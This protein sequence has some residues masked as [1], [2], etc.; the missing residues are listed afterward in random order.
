MLAFAGTL[1]LSQITAPAHAVESRAPITVHCYDKKRDLVRVTGRYGCRH[2][3]VGAKFAAEVTKRRRSYVKTA[4]DVQRPPTEAAGATGFF[5]SDAGDVI[6][7]KH[8]VEHCRR[9][10]IARRNMPPAP[11]TV[12]AISDHHDLA[13]IRARGLDGEAAIIAGSE[14]QPGDE[15]TVFG[16]P[17]SSKRKDQ[18]TVSAGYF[19]KKWPYTPGRHVLALQ[20]PVWPGSSGSPVVDADGKVSGV[21]FAKLQQRSRSTATMNLVATSQPEQAFAVPATALLDFVR[22]HGVERADPSRDP[23][24]LENSV[25][26]VN[27]LK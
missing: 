14:M 2:S 6:T 27:C 4:I 11:A 3:V 17:R 7:N 18:A 13:L 10:S 16:F 15:I 19:L 23:P 20:V 1:A 12:A 21:V 26:H 9:L 25:V 5:V 22:A 8:V 24:A